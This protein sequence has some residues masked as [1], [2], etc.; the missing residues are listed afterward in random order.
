MVRARAPTAKRRARFA[1]RYHGVDILLH[2]SIMEPFSHMLRSQGCQISC[3]G[4]D[5]CGRC[6]P[7]HR[8]R[9]TSIAVAIGSRAAPIARSIGRSRFAPSR[10]GADP[11]FPA[12]PR[13][14]PGAGA[15][16]TRRAPRRRH[17]RSDRP[18][19]FGRPI[20]GRLILGVGRNGRYR[21]V[22]ASLPVRDLRFRSPNRPD[23]E[24]IMANRDGS[25]P[26]SRSNTRC[27]T[28]GGDR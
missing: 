25:G 9:H 20:R 3:P 4:A 18:A 12:R 7:M 17:D 13:P 16:P 11:S 6:G 10:N 24:R 8:A 1:R 28:I 22:A 23:K 5:A 26:I 14:E 27:A 21:G 2:C 19:T 15:N